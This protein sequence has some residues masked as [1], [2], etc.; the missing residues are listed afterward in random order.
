VYDASLLSGSDALQEGGAGASQAFAGRGGAGTA[1]DGG[2]GGQGAETSGGGAGEAGVGAG[3]SSVIVSY[4]GTGAGGS[5]S[6]GADSGGSSVGGN[7]AGGAPGGGNGS[8]G[9]NSAGSGVG[10]PVIRELAKGKPATASTIQTGN[11]AKSGNDGDSATRWCASSGMMPQW[12]RVDLGDT[13]HLTQVVIKFEHPERKY[14]YVLETSSN[15]AVYTQRAMV[16][17]TGDNQA[18]DMPA[19]VSARYLRITVT[20]GAPGMDAAGTVYPTWASFWELRAYGY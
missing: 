9:A 5:D 12:W 14:T 3:G 16:N 2:R 1:S 7:A 19:D 11:V 13:F 6:G 18:V 10:S 20:D 8:A 15:D 17:G 4:G